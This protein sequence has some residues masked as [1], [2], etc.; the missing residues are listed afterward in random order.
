MTNKSDLFNQAWN[1]AKEGA[2]KFGGS[3]REYF[4]AALKIAYVSPKE[5]AVNYVSLKTWFV[6]KNFSESEMFIAETTS[7]NIVKETEKAVQLLWDSKYGKMFKWAPKSCMITE[8]EAIAIQEKEV[9]AFKKYE[10]LIA[11]AKENNVKGVRN[12]MKKTTIIV[13]IQAA[14]LVAPAELV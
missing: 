13:K 6:E 12:R 9:S 3:S 5:V 2:S 7:F 1:L 8:Q 4:A 11:W 10:K 14:G